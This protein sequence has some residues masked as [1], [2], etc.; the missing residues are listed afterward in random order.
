MAYFEI[1]VIGG[2]NTRLDNAV[3]LDSDRYMIPVGGTRDMLLWNASETP[4]NVYLLVGH[5]DLVFVKDP[6]HYEDIQGSR[7]VR[8]VRTDNS[9]PLGGR[10]FIDGLAPGEYFPFRVANPSGSATR[11]WLDSNSCTMHTAGHGTN[12]FNGQRVYVLGHDA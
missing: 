3:L 7:N 5:P 9:L 4:V 12:I 10:I 1:D 8:D 2:G 6:D 11:I